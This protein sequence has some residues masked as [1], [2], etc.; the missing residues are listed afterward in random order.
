K[1]QLLLKFPNAQIVGVQNGFFSEAEEGK[2]VTCANK[3]KPQV[4]FVAM[5]IP[6]QEKFIA[7][8]LHEIGAAVNMGVGGSF[9][10]LSGTVKRAPKLLQSLRL[11][12]LWRLIQ[13]PKKW[14]K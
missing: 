1:E 4:L 9:D 12:W 6:K 14:R 8:Y 5:G 11:E 7:K 3:S 10:V 2:V 13:N